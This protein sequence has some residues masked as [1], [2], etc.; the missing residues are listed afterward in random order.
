MYPSDRSAQRLRR[1]RAGARVIGWLVTFIGAGH[2]TAWLTG[3]MAERGLSSI[4]MKTNAALGLVCVG[5]AIVLLEAADAGRWRRRAAQALAVIAAVL[6]SLTLLENLTG[7]N[8]YIDE[9]L[10]S[11]HQ[12]AL[13]AS[14]ANR[15]GIPAS[16]SFLLAGISLLLFSRAK[17]RS[18]A[19]AQWLALA[20]CLISLL[21]CVGYLYGAQSFY[22]VTR[23]TAIAWPT[24]GSLLG[25]GLGLLL[26]RP[27]EGLMAQVTADDP[28]GVALRRWPPL[29]VLPL[30]LGW[31]RLSGERHGW[32]DAATGTALVML[33]VIVAFAVVAFRGSL[34][35]SRS[36][37][38]LVDREERLRL[39]QEAAG[40]GA[41]DWNVRR[42][43]NFWTPELEAIHGLAAGSFRQT[44]RAWEDLIHPDDREAAA[45]KIDEA[46]VAGGTVEC[47]WRV[48]WPDAGVHWISSRW[49]VFRDS[50]G[51][52]VRMVGVSLEVTERR[53]I[54][55]ALET[56]IR[57]LERSNRELEQFAYICAHDLQE[58]LRQ[59]LLFV[60]LLREDCGGDLDGEA[61]EYLDRIQQGGQRMNDLIVGVLQYARAGS[62]D[63][64]CELVSCEEVVENAVANLSAAIGDCGASV[65]RDPLPT[66]K[67]NRTQ[68]TQLFHNL[69]SNGV[70]FRRD[71]VAPQVHIGCGRDGD[72]WVFSV[73]DNGIGIPAEY[74]AKLFRIFQRLH[75]QEAYQGTGIG[76]AV[77]KKI[78]E[79][80][81]GRIWIEGRV[82]GGSV[83]RF[84]VPGVRRSFEEGV[85]KRG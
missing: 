38:A 82:G 18:P 73:E 30:L 67:G 13:G 35:V 65:T 16:T 8:L 14:S 21:A 47:E 77:C 53:R 27:A 71:G 72:G 81:G 63:D 83:F 62:S 29:L 6:G 45:R 75:G 17:P 51:A 41:F 64:G 70:K 85:E 2:L 26:I 84:T 74:H 43:F 40:I 49:R 52:A 34:A 7:W 57:N 48:V 39:S 76:L 4:T 78:V 36:S 31:L 10:A 1:F 46:L 23:I 59:V 44:R 3:Y 58:P 32:F 15:M 12:G 56:T 80:H 37:A 22:A 61:A 19:L 28:G 55:E 60:Q 5:L 79:A 42:D 9:I 50:S 69:I 25:L 33:C 11:E 54:Q 20:I 24:A 66:V 68:L